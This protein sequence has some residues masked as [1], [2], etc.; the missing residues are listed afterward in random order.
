[1]TRMMRLSPL[2]IAVTVL[3]LFQTLS[4]FDKQIFGV[5]A[6]PLGQSLDLTDVE[7]GL[8]LGVAFAI[9][10]SV[11]TLCFGWAADRFSPRNILFVCVLLWSVAAFSTGLASS[12]VGVMFARML[13]G[14]GESALQPCA[15]KI[16][17]EVSPP[18]RLGLAG[19]LYTAGGI[20]GSAGT[21]IVAGSIM[22]RLTEAGG[23]DLPLIGHV[24]PWQASFM[25][26]SL[27]GII[28]CS[29]AFLLP[30]LTPRAAPVDGVRP[31]A[32]SSILGL[33]RERRLLLFCHFG[34]LTLLGISL[35]AIMSWAPVYMTRKFGMDL[36]A[37]GLIM[38][39]ATAAG[40][41]A[42]IFWGAVS[43]WL[44]ARGSVTVTYR[45]YV[46]LCAISAVSGGAAFIV[47]S[48]SMF[49][50]LLILSTVSGNFSALALVMP[51][52]V[53]RDLIGRLFGFQSFIFGSF[54]AGFA[55]LL[56]AFLTESLFGDPS[57]VG[58]AIGLIVAVCGIGSALLLAIGVG[59][60][61]RAVDIIVRVDQPVAEDCATS[62]NRPAAVAAPIA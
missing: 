60:L 22:M 26:L 40:A 57:A 54:G 16:L 19:S 11:G 38:G 45:M 58:L 9:P 39:I 17:V 24:E 1:M 55:P 4:Y 41:I 52:F 30:K 43:D 61:A 50:A 46:P 28:L 3:M 48:Q 27:P 14:L 18:A 56:V 23:A 53:P 42:G 36:G 35:F 59:P 29:A 32:G 13:L 15:Y 21:L 7:L 44:R 34:T 37:I 25:L 12:F 20:L 51:F 33:L 62:A 8:L 31:E 5:L 49:T 6:P 2:W 47:D 10:Y